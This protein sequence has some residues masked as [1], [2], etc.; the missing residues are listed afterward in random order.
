MGLNGGRGCY[1]KEAAVE[2]VPMQYDNSETA[3]LTNFSRP[4]FLLRSNCFVPNND[5]TGEHSLL[6]NAFGPFL[7]EEL[8]R[9]YKQMDSG[10]TSSAKNV[11]HS[12]CARNTVSTASQ[13]F[14][15]EEIPFIK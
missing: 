12:S 13:L 10:A 11:G 2:P 9:D 14:T 6:K 7:V 1:V 4:G 3:N 5:H 8:S 15:I